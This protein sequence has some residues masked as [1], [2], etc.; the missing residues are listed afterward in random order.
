MSAILLSRQFLLIIFIH[1][2]SQYQ[3]ALFQ[4]KRLNLRLAIPLV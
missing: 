4:F 2:P 1:F 3:K